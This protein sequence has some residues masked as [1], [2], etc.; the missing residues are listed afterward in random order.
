MAQVTAGCKGCAGVSGPAGCPVHQSGANELVCRTCGYRGP[1]SGHGPCSSDPMVFCR[2]LRDRIQ[3]LETRILH[4]EQ[5]GAPAVP[6]PENGERE[7]TLAKLGAAWRRAKDTLLTDRHGEAL[8]EVRV[9]LSRL[10]PN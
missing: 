6:S 8:D 5:D 1:E 10:F 2:I 3:G 7:E 9:L 4:L